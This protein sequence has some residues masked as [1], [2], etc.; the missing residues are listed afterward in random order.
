VAIEVLIGVE[1]KATMKST[2]RLNKEQ[3]VKDAVVLLIGGSSNRG[4]MNLVSYTT[5]CFSCSSVD[6]RSAAL[7]AV[8]KSAS[9]GTID[10]DPRQFP[11][12]N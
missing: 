3:V 7:R 2:I 1:V 6:V 5:F 4:P 9:G 10:I 12:N 11:G 8:L